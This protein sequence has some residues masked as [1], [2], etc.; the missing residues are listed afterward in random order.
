MDLRKLR[1]EMAARFEQAK[2]N[3]TEPRGVSYFLPGIIRH[4]I[5]KLNG[6]T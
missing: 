5:Q 4:I 3:Q 6:E 2:M 1:R